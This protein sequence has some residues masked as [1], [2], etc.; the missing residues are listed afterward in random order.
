MSSAGTDK[1]G[2]EKLACSELQ[3]EARNIFKALYSWSFVFHWISSTLEWA[4]L[5]TWVHLRHACLLFLP[6][7]LQWCTSSKGKVNIIQRAQ[8]LLQHGSS[9]N[10]TLWL[11]AINDKWNGTDL[12]LP[13]SLYT[14]SKLPFIQWGKTD[15]KLP[16]WILTLT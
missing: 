2:I 1:E 12:L 13:H 11:H 16:S 15:L 6:W 10:F 7:S 5:S 14:V 9:V 4:E 8:M 3:S